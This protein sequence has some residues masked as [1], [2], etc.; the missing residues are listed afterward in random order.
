MGYPERVVQ[1]AYHTVTPM[2][3]PGVIPKGSP[4]QIVTLLGHCSESSPAAPCSGAAAGG[5]SRPCFRLLPGA[6]QGVAVS[7]CCPQGPALHA[8]WQTGV[9]W[10]FSSGSSIRR[11]V[12]QS[13]ARGCCEWGWLPGVARGPSESCCRR[14][15]PGLQ[16]SEGHPYRHFA[17]VSCWS[18]EGHNKLCTKTSQ[19]GEYTKYTKSSI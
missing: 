9:A 3:A 18:A 12:A 8:G 13:P 14:P 16:L 7:G 2:S 17:Y 19:Q 10:C 1:R 4:V 6:Q 5:G 11:V 15:R